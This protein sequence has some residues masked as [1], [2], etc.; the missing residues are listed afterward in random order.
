MIIKDEPELWH[1]LKGLHRHEGLEATR[2][3]VRE[4]ISRLSLGD[5]GPSRV[6]KVIEEFLKAC[7]A[8]HLAKQYS[9]MPGEASKK[10]PL[11]D[12]SQGRNPPTGIPAGKHPLEV[13]HLDST[14]LVH[15]AVRVV[16]V[17]VCFA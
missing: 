14:T 4:V 10:R 13:V 11:E 6:D 1:F 2:Y 3:K 9:K 8:C 7:S 16:K 15:S 12:Q 17:L 5:G